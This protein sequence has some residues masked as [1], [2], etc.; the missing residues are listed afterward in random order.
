MGL[1]PT[2]YGLTTCIFVTFLPPGT[3]S[4]SAVTSKGL[5]QSLV[6]FPPGVLS[7]ISF[8]VLNKAFLHEQTKSSY[9]AGDADFSPSPGELLLLCRGGKGKETVILKPLRLW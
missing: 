1:P 6:L 4:S 3:F 9:Q 2:G 8:A 5:V 7:F